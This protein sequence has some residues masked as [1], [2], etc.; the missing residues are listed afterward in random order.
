MPQI[1]P[2]EKVE[3]TSI[4]SDK[5]NDRDANGQQTFD[6]GSQERKPPMSEEQLQKAV[7]HL[8]SLPTVKEHRWTVHLAAGE[9]S[10][11][12]VVIKDNLGNVIR[13]I[14]EAELWSL[15]ID[16]PTTKGHLLKKSA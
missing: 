8:A 13:K 2:A 6:Q 12:V 5:T 15:P 3:T 4:H 16:E 1:R 7:A 11:K 10:E 14:P 9:N